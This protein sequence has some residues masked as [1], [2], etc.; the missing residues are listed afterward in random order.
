MARRNLERKGLKRVD[1]DSKKQKLNH[2]TNY[3][4]K[5]NKLGQDGTP[6]KYF[7]CSSECLTNC[8]CPCRYHFKGACMNIEKISWL[9]LSRP[10]VQM[11]GQIKQSWARI[12]S[13]S[14]ADQ[15]ILQRRNRKKRSCKENYMPWF[16]KSQAGGD[17][18]S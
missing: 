2:N 18:N 9:H 4:G 6:L 5:K 14:I 7:R 3:K 16:H 15:G 10:K 8:N 1:M 11:I 17:L 13:G 12:H